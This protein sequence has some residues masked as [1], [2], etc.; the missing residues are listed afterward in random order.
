MEELMTGIADLDR[1][2]EMVKQKTGYPVSVT[3][4]SSIQTHAA[5]RSATRDMPVHMVLVNPKYEKFSNYLVTAQCAMLLIKWADSERIPD[6]SVADQRKASIEA[7]LMKK[8]SH[9]GI[10]EAAQRQFVSQLVSGLLLQL[11]SVPMEL[12]VLDWCHRECH[13]L[14]EEQELEVHANLRELS[15]NLDPKIREM[16]PGEIYERSVAMNA[17]F[18]LR[19]SHLTGNLQALLPYRALGFLQ[20][21]EQLINLLEAIP[22]G[23]LDLYPRVVDAWA[24]ELVMNGWYSWIYR[25]G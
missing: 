1:V 24:K 21:G 9:K 7:D 2:I 18:V 13:G 5:M 11:A 25:K 19:W 16:V 15:A 14:R 12:V 20:K 3:P 10:P 4:S 8:T 17:A 6:F 23:A 22:A